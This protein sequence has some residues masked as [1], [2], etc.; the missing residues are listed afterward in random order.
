MSSKTLLI[1][2]FQRCSATTRCW[3]D[4]NGVLHSFWCDNAFYRFGPGI[5]SDSCKT[6][7]GH[8]CAC[9][10][11]SVLCDKLLSIHW[12]ISWTDAIR[13]N[14]KI[15]PEI[16]EGGK[17]L[18]RKPLRIFTLSTLQDFYLVPDGG[19]G[20]KSSPRATQS[21]SGM[22]MISGFKVP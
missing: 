19:P 21:D 17:L 6:S 22:R 12:K 7:T 20:K 2:T 16:S 8:F 4:L 18:V 10:L 1:K 15:V 9:W 5:T 14:A 13:E 3:L 11:I